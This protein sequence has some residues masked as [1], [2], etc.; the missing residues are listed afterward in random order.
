VPIFDS[1]D[2]IAIGLTEQ[3]HRTGVNGSFMDG[4]G[5]FRS[6]EP[7]K[8]FDGGGTFT[9]DDRCF[10]RGFLYMIDKR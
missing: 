5:E 8:Q 4:H 1:N 10:Y 9:S 2:A 7:L 6:L 3:V